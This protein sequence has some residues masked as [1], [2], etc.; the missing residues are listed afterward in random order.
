MG[1]AVVLTFADDPFPW[2]VSVAKEYL[3]LEIGGEDLMLSVGR[4][5]P[6]VYGP[7]AAL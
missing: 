3:E 1:D 5:H 7:L 4:C 2:A 6:D